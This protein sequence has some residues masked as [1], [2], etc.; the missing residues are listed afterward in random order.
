MIHNQR[1]GDA[2]GFVRWEAE[3]ALIAGGF[4][5]VYHATTSEDEL[6]GIL[7]G[8]EGLLIPI[9][10]DGT[11]RSVIRRM[12]QL[13]LKRPLT[14]LP[15]GTANNVARHLGIQGDWRTLLRG[16]SRARRQPF[17]VGRASGRW[18]VDYFLE[19]AGVGLFADTLERYLPDDGKDV[20]KALRA[21]MDVLT[22][23][24]TYPI[25]MALD[26]RKR[27]G[28]Y[29]MVEVLNIGS[30]GPRLPLH[31]QA[32]PTDGL[33][34]VFQ[35][36]ADQREPLLLYFTALLTGDLADLAG[37]AVERVREVQLRASIR[38]PL[39]L[40]AEVR[41]AEPGEVLSLDVLPSQLEIWVP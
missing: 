23:Y 30:V 10:G 5:P 41:W 15:A 18:G 22:D 24:R 36:V 12:L 29:L 3:A 35:L 27:H 8:A 11:V 19:G 40:D 21:I 31:P 1:A 20:L 14:I 26:G 34:D 16:L 32:D 38:F 13:G 37:V 17:D 6:D 39:H 25:S 2:A 9:G 4:E 7:P 33:L 28:R